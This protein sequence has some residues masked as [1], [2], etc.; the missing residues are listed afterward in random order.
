MILVNGN[1]LGRARKTILCDIQRIMVDGSF[2]GLWTGSVLI[3]QSANGSGDGPTVM[4]AGHL[5]SFEFHEKGVK[6][7]FILNIWRLCLSLKGFTP[8]QVPLYMNIRFP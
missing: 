5:V 4:L 2:A 3:T 8:I 6:A 7:S 1:R